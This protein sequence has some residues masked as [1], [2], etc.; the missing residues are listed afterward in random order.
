MSQK[1]LK[2]FSILDPIVN[3]D[4]FDFYGLLHQEAPVYQIPETGAY[5]ITKYKDLKRVLRDYQ[6]FTNDLT[7]TD[8]G[9]FPGLHQAVLRDGGGWEHV[10]TLQRSTNAKEK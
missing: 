6:S 2:D 9:P 10:Q 5:V 4:P 3:S 7:V 8:Q 1:L